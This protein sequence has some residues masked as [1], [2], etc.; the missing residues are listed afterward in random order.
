MKFVDNASIEVAQCD[1][2][3]EGLEVIC[4]VDGGVYTII[5]SLLVCMKPYQKYKDHSISI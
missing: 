3:P 1:E 2:I 4:E 5:E